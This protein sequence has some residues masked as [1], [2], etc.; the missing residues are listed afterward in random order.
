MRVS[1]DPGEKT[2]R[3]P[4]GTPRPISFHDG[5]LELDLAVRGRGF[6]T[7][8][9]PE[10]G[11][12]DELRRDV[13]AAAAAALESLLETGA[14]TWADLEGKGLEALEEAMEEALAR[15]G[16][17]AGVRFDSFVPD[18]A[19][20]KAIGEK[21]AAAW[22]GRPIPSAPVDSPMIDGPGA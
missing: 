20:A 18:E 6:V 8:E 15:A 2:L 14:W 10:G 22:E 11:D 1:F 12:M 19:S 16:R 9:E 17:R 7:V 13:R 4:F 5:E 3:I 21:R